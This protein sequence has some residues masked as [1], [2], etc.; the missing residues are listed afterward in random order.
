MSTVVETTT[1][2]ESTTV[3]ESP[4]RASL[5]TPAVT[6]DPLLRYGNAFYLAIFGVLHAL[7]ALSV[8]G[9]GGWASSWLGTSSLSTAVGVGAW[10]ATA[11][12][13]VLGAALLA[14]GRGW[15]LPLTVA[16]AASTLLCVAWFGQAG[17]GLVVDA[18]VIL[19]LVASRPRN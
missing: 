2:A 8:W 14:V 12:L 5:R 13:F 3:V 4:A 6:I 1:P 16:A 11:A 15:R 7:A 17:I 10:F 9:R 19:G 18:F